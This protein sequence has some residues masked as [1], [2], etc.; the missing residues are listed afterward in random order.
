MDNPL[1][2]EPEIETEPDDATVVGM[3]DEEA[4]DVLSALSSDTAREILRTLYSEPG[5]AS[6]VADRTDTTIQNAQYHLG[7]L[8]SAGLIEVADTTYSPKGREM[9][10]YVPTGRAVVVV[11]DESDAETAR[12]FLPEFLLALLPLAAVAAAAELLLN[13]P[14]WPS[15]AGGDSASG[16]DVQTADNAE[17][18]GAAGD[19][20]GSVSDPSLVTQFGNSPG[21][22]VF[23]GGLCALALAALVVSLR[24]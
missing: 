3:D 5:P 1:S 23:L 19:A 16:G 12:E 11:P 10:V 20:G 14:F 17:A 18:L 7:K 9:D 13:G 24:R 15:S 8:A 6:E 21:V 2:S 22:A 4:G